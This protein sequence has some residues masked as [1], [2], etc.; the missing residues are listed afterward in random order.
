MKP[1]V[2]LLISFCLVAQGIVAA[3][4]KPEA[5]KAW[6]DPAKV[7]DEDFLIQGEFTGEDSGKKMGVQIW[8]QGDGKFEA[9][10]YQGGLPGDGWD[11]D[12]STV[13]RMKGERVAGEKTVKFEQ[14][15][16]KAVADGQ[17][18]SVVDGKG[19]PVATLKRVARQSPTMGAKPPQGAV[20]LFD[21][22]DAAHFPDGKVT[23]EGLLEQGATSSDKFGDCTLHVE[24]MLSFKPFARGQDRGNSGVYV[25]GRYEVQVLDSFA[26]EGKDNECG[27]IYSIAAPKQ[28]MCF[29]PLV[30]QTYDIDFTAAKYDAAG[31]KTTNAKMTVKHNGVTVHE[32]VDLSHSTTAAPVNEGPEPGPLHLQNHGNPA[33]YR[34]IWFLAK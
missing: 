5:G 17:S 2:L 6:M 12:R 31:K 18:F 23:P 30:W 27:G 7:E 11:G 15:D 28:N 25:Q 13:S 21:G 33:R 29:P 8:A 32:N 26:L 16:K 14:P 20:V 9:V 22:K 19:Q 4:K 3:P 10:K 24:F 1:F 34:N